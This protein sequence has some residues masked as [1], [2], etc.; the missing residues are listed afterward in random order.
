ML[1]LPVCVGGSQTQT[2]TNFFNMDTPDIIENEDTIES[3]GLTVSFN[4]ETSEITFEWDPDTHPEFNYLSELSAE[5]IHST[6]MKHF[7]DTVEQARKDQTTE[8]SNVA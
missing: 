1:L 6:L 3:K 2:L 4:Q 5:D 7:A 8:K